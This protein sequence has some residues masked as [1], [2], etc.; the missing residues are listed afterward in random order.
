VPP[1]VGE[2]VAIGPSR[3]GAASTGVLFSI[4]IDPADTA[5]I[6]VASPFCGV[7]K[8]E[9]TGASWRVVGD[10]LPAELPVAALASDPSTSG[11]IYALLQGGQLYRSD[12][13][14]ASWIQANQ[15]GNGLGGVTP[16][17]TDL[18]VHPLQPQVL[19]A[20]N[21]VGCWRSGDGG[22]TWRVTFYGNFSHLVLDQTQ[23]DVLYAGTPDGTVY[24]TVNGGLDWN[25]LPLPFLANVYDTKIALTRTDSQVI[26]VRRQKHLEADVYMSY[27][28]GTT[29]MQRSSPN[30]YT[31]LIAA[32]DDNAS[33]V[34]VAGVDFYRSDDGGVTWTIKPGAHVDHHRFARDPQDPQTI[35][36][37]CD[38]GLYRS[39]DRGDSWQFVGDGLENVLFY[40]LALSAT[41]PEI[42]I[43]GTQDNG[44]ALYDGS[45]TAW[46]EILGGDGG[47]VA[48]DPSNGSVMYAMNQYAST[49]A[50]STDGGISFHNIA[51]G[52]PTG[53]V[54]F[55]LHFQ[56]HPTATNIL[57][58][59]TGSLWWTQQPGT[60]WS[61][62]FTPPDYP[63]ESVVR[64]A[65]D[66]SRDIYY[67]ATARGRL[68]AAASGNDWQLV[69]SHP[70]GHG[71]TD[72][73]ID[74]D[75]TTLIYAS[76]GGFTSG[77]VYRLRRFASTPAALQAT[78]ITSGL[79][80][81]AL[82]QTLAVDAMVPY[83]IYAGIWE[84]GV[85]RGSSQNVGDLPVWTSY[86]I[87]MPPAADV[88]ALRVHRAT[89]VMRAATWGRSAYEVNTGDPIGSLIETIGHIFFLRAHDLGTGYGKAPNFLDCEV[90]V[91]L[92]EEPYRA[93]GFKL[94]AD[95]EQPT[96]NEMLDL[97]RSAFVTQRPVRLDYIKT[98]PRV[99]EIIRVANG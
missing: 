13:G 52:L 97:L 85:F 45:S 17:V 74:P 83:T 87:G 51:D 75:D 33:I 57:L 12:D 25:Y 1:S 43:G 11:R 68:Y 95:Q 16:A 94:R 28:G 66:P 60:P 70:D 67:A 26:Y 69:F 39:P 90:I 64:S 77:R 4:A 20:R 8:T 89:G 91:L 78:D 23:P 55:N 22:Q 54:G 29:W 76:F 84:S 38:G 41:Q 62:L 63:N 42:A 24:R 27:D 46:K 6:Y 96:R 88:R 32:D 18:I 36:T 73:V 49:I 93:F 92:S 40:D 21:D 58:A 37:A 65:V 7:W 31:E 47:T 14:A 98:G 81:G 19:H 34:Y 10:S 3:I 80:S 86:N 56:V 61:A 99:G 72:L 53:A 79:A 30:I 9:D 48:I 71:F 2:W 44:T 15:V 82:V 59:S 5:V 50:Q 35:Y